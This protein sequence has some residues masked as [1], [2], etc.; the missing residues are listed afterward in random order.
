MHRTRPFDYF[1]NK[2]TQPGERQFQ[3]NAVDADSMYLKARRSAKPTSDPGEEAGAWI[4]ECRLAEWR[5]FVR[6]GLWEMPALT[7]ILSSMLVSLHS[8]PDCIEAQGVE[9]PVSDPRTRSMQDI[10]CKR[11][12]N[13]PN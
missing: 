7:A 2:P 11:F 10:G 3:D 13:K 5:E 12:R 6:S 4:F 8:W 9:V 1:A